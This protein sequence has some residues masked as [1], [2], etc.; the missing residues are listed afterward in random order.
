LQAGSVFCIRIGATPIRRAPASQERVER[1]NRD[2]G[3]QMCKGQ[4][5]PTY[6]SAHL[7]TLQRA[8]KTVDMG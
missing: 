8:W 3:A 4:L 7:K 1:L 2:R 6:F 5:K